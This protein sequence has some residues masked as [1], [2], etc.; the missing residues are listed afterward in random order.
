MM[1]IIKSAGKP[2]KTGKARRGRK[3]RASQRDARG[4]KISSVF[5]SPSVLGVL[6]F[7]YFIG[8]NLLA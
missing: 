7:G 1:K 3:K 2:E 5:L 8:K 6:V 4:R